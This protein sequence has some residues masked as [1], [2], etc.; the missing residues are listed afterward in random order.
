M[1][2][3]DLVRVSQCYDVITCECFFCHHNSNGVGLVIRRGDLHRWVVL[4][5]AGEWELADFEVEVINESR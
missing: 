5:D 4:F 3:G 1:Q 2:V